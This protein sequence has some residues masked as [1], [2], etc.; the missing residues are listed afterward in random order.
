MFVS[1]LN[2]ALEYVLNVKVFTKQLLEG[3]FLPYFGRVNETNEKG[4]VPNLFLFVIQP[5]SSI[6]WVTSIYLFKRQFS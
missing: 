1:V 3:L 4:Y 2:T 6:S 5:V